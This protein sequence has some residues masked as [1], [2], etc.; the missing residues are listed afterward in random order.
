MSLDLSKPD[1][2]LAKLNLDDQ[3]SCPV[4]TNKYY[5]PVTL[6]CQHTFCS[7]CIQDDKIT[8]CP[9][10]QLNIFIPKEAIDYTTANDNIIGKIVELYQGTDEMNEIKQDVISYMEEK[11]MTPT[12]KK[13][14]EN[15]IVNELNN[16]ALINNQ[17]NIQAG[18]GAA[19]GIIEYHATPHS[20]TYYDKIIKI[21]KWATLAILSFFFGWTF[22]DLLNN[23]IDL[24][25]G[26]GT[27]N[28]VIYPLVRCMG[29]VNI[30][31]QYYKVFFP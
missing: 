2:T 20:D 25:I 8:K 26:K 27:V 9:V 19:I 4:C 15:N 17:G 21:C 13:E 7:H 18:G 31:L 29:I 11:H 1:P 23:V 28:G 10:C 22:G 24:F 6:L 30:L 3:L 14:M 16:L 5:N 12:I